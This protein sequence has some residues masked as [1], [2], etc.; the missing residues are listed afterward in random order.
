[1]TF[2]FQVAEFEVTI[3][4]DTKE[5]A[6]KKILLGPLGAV[7]LKEATKRTLDWRK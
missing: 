6:I 5:A 7:A 4:A 3:V 1:M 2:K